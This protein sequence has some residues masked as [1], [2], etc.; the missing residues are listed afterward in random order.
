VAGR[1]VVDGF[2]GVGGSA[3]HFARRCSHVIAVDSCRPRLGLAAHNAGVYRVARR[4][5][6]ICADFLRLPAT[7]Q[8][9]YLL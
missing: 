9:G 4:L 5:D 1:V 8:V 2:C 7:L 3:V 6:L